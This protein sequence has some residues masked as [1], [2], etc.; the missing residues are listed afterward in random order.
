MRLSLLCAALAVFAAGCSVPPTRLG[1]D[2]ADLESEIKELESAILRGH[3]RDIAKRMKGVS[4]RAAALSATTFVGDPRRDLADRAAARVRELRAERRSRSSPARGSLLQIAEA[5]AKEVLA[6]V[7]VATPDVKAIP[8]DLDLSPLAMNMGGDADAAPEGAPDADF[9]RPGAR[10]GPQEREG[11]VDDVPVGAARR[12]D[13]H[14]GPGRGP[15]FDENSRPLVVAKPIAKEKGAIA[16]VYYYNKFKT[17]HIGA[18]SGMFVGSRH[19]AKAQVLATYEAKGF[20]PNWGDI[21]NSRG[22]V[23]TMESTLAKEKQVVKL[24]CVVEAAQLGEIKEVSV[25][26]VLR[27]GA[28][29]SAV[30]K[31]GL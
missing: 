15:Q 18:V 5:E 22:K 17:T 28:T 10:R 6:R 31:E 14:P 1:R 2:A 30:W 27:N 11:D 24:V 20:V 4:E 26:I 3:E 29:H 7:E 21:L 8:K 9:D 19:G 12:G 13:G 25:E 16:Y 23:V